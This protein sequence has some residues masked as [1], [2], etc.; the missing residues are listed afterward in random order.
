MIEKIRTEVRSTMVFFWV[1]FIGD[2]KEQ[3]ID[4]CH[5]EGKY[6]ETNR[7]NTDD[8]VKNDTEDE[9]SSGDYY[10]VG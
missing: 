4:V 8:E 7:D 5:D 1:F 10:K 9:K 2:E 6:D 3:H